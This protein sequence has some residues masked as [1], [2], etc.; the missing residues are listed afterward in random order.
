M[1]SPSPGEVRDRFTSEEWSALL[2]TPLMATL[3][4]VAASP[5]G[6]FG[7][8]REMLAAGRALAGARRGEVTNPLAEA[9]ATDIAMT[10]QPDGREPDEARHA[11]LRGMGPDQVRGHALERLREAVG[12]L[13]RK[14]PDDETEGFKRWLFSISLEVAR[15]AKEGGH[16]GFG[17]KRVSDEEAAALRQTAWA[18]GLP[19]P[20]RGDGTS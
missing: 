16:F 18:L 14:A 1:A 6:P 7:I 12:I 10:S 2:R 4:V 11:D 5:S 13:Y 17:G 3:V 15:A 19:A 20:E 8:A 9:I